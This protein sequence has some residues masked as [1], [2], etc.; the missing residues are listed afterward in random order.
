MFEIEVI[1][2]ALKS[3]K[4]IFQRP[5]HVSKAGNQRGPLFHGCIE[6]TQTAVQTVL[7]MTTMGQRVEQF[8]KQVHAKTQKVR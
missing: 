1:V 7:M 6:V 4:S 5:Q 3:I 2:H 8:L